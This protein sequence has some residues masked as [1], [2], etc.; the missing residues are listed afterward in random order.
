MCGSPAFFPVK[1]VETELNRHNSYYE[2]GFRV[3]I[4]WTTAG[5]LNMPASI[6]GQLGLSGRIGPTEEEACIP[7]RPQGSREVVAIEDGLL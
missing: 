2:H 4:H 7:T 3:Q 6:L 5:A 1:K